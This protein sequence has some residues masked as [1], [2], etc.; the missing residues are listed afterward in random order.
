MV[1]SRKRLLSIKKLK[2]FVI[3]VDGD[4]ISWVIITIIIV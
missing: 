4:E 3:V 2:H 1:S